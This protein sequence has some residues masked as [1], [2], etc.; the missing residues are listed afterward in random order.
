MGKEAIASSFVEICRRMASGENLKRIS[1]DLNFD[2]SMFLDVTD[3]S[4]DRIKLYA[5]ARER[6]MEAWS[7]EIDQIAADGSHDTIET[8]DGR[9]ICNHEWIARS[10]LMVDTRK[11]LMSKLS[12]RKYGDKLA[13]EQSGKDGGPVQHIYTWGAPVGPEQSPVPPKK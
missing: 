8:S 3:E 2:R 12:P 10:R 11:W 9:E 6:L 5:R 4:E 7:D 13:V 1:E